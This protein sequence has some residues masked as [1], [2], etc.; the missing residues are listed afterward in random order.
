M[1]NRNAYLAVALDDAVLASLACSAEALRQDAGALLSSEDSLRF[2]PQEAL[3][4]TFIFF[5][6][7]LRELPAEELR[8]LHAAVQTATASSEAAAAPLEFLHFELFPPGKL[9]QVAAR[10]AATPSL[11]LLRAGV[12]EQLR[13]LAPS[14]PRRFWA[15]IEEEGDWLPHV[16]LGK[17]TGATA[18]EIGRLSCHGPLQARAPS[19]A[20]AQGLTLLGEPPKRVWL[21]WHDALALPG[22]VAVHAPPVLARARSDEYGAGASAYGE[23][24]LERWRAF[25][26]EGMDALERGVAEDDNSAKVALLVEASEALHSAVQLRPDFKK[27]LKAQVQAERLL[28][29]ARAAAVQA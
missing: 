15:G 9:N 18:A 8:S 12:L 6:E 13:R 7:A 21:D 2:D 23:D 19:A 24:V 14:L 3:H 25:G 11:R 4:M 27:G 29:E 26:R 16:T 22:A 17:L 20:R 10:F 5:G 1:P 28:K